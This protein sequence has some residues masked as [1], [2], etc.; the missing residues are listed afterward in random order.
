MQLFQLFKFSSV[1][2]VPLEIVEVAKTLTG[3]VLPLASAESEV[4]RL[5][6]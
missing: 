6:K 3:N 5:A 4:L 1:G 2:Y